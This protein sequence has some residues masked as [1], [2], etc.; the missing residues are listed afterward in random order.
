M[1]ISEEFYGLFSAS[2][3]KQGESYVISIPEG[4]LLRND[5]KQGEPACLDAMYMIFYGRVPRT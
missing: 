1:K 5:L 3:E 4:E 2:V